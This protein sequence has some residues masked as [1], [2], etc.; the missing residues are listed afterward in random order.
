MGRSLGFAVAVWLMAPLCL[1][2]AD[3]GK[4]LLDAASQGRATVVE[5][6]LGKGAPLESKDKTGRTALMLAAQRGHVETVRLLLAKGA[7]P[8]VRDQTGATAWVL[9]VF[10]SNGVR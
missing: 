10:S 7:D 5:D 2:S 1:V 8:A 9:A 6:L 4:A 3:L